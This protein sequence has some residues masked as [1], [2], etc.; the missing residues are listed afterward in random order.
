MKPV[1]VGAGDMTDL[2]VPSS[3]QVTLKVYKGKTE[4][5]TQVRVGASN[6]PPSQK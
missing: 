5:D 6:Q 1:R 3:D 4:K 2:I